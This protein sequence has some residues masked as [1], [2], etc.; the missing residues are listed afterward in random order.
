MGDLITKTAATAWLR[1]RKHLRRGPLRDDAGPRDGLRPS[2][3]GASWQ[4]ISSHYSE[5]CDLK[6]MNRLILEFS[7]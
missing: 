5:V 4:E 2:Q 7:I 6:L 1:S 3:G